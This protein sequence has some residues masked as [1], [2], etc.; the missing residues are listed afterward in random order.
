VVT[1]LTKVAGLDAFA[2]YIFV[3]DQLVRGRYGFLA[4]HSNKNDFIS[5]YHRIK[6]IL[7]RKYGRPLEDETLWKNDLYRDDPDEYGFAVSLGHLVYYANWKTV[8]TEI[9][10]VLHGENYRI[11][12][13]LEYRS[14]ELAALESEHRESEEESGF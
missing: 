3:S 2:I 8:H 11:V 1:Y 5:D 13:V 14:I 12:H 4:E 7:T 10:L 6:S 9:S